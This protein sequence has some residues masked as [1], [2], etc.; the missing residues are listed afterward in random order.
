[1]I[2]S[3]WVPASRV[4]ILKCCEKFQAGPACLE[5]GGPGVCRYAGA[6]QARNPRTVVVA[7]QVFE[8]SY[9]RWLAAQGPSLREPARTLA[10]PRLAHHPPGQADRTGDAVDGLEGEGT[11]CAR[12][13]L[14]AIQI[15]GPNPCG[16]T[17][18]RS[19]LASTAN[20]AVEPV[21]SRT[22]ALPQDGSYWPRRDSNP[23]PS[24]YEPPALTAELQGR[25]ND[26]RWAAGHGQSGW[27]QSRARVRI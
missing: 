9:R 5:H 24:G 17:M 7:P 21:A 4:R 19:R 27:T 22:C 3:Q 1:M 13:S 16:W 26:N 20:L 11:G 10:R 8:P 18:A 12:I 23:G 2:P 14:R 25:V 15:Q 6:A